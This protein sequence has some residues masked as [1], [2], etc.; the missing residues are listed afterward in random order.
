MAAFASPIPYLIFFAPRIELRALSKISPGDELTVSYVDF[1]NVSEERRKQLKKQYYFDCTC[2]HCKKKIKDDLMLAVK[3][4]DKKVWSCGPL[5]QRWLCLLHSL[6][7]CWGHP[8]VPE[9]GCGSLEQRQ[10]EKWG[11]DW[12]IIELNT[13]SNMHGQFNPYYVTGTQ[14]FIFK[15]PTEVAFN[16]NLTLQQQAEW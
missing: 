5:K 8:T 11:Q 14:V 12:N 15:K 7:H 1:L 4:G 2:E 16:S 10:C 6:W 13:K 3:E 9:S